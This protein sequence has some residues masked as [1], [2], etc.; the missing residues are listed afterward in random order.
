MSERTGWVKLYR[1][2][3]Y[4]QWYQDDNVFHLFIHLLFCATKEVYSCRGV[5][6]SPGD[7]L[8]TLP[9]LA[10]ELNKTPKQIRTAL[11]KLESTGE[12]TKTR[13][14]KFIVIHITNFERYQN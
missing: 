5:E 13:Y 14:N 3:L 2:M 6:L 10:K 7:Y 12:I 11:D 9:G 8:T 1:Q 4:W